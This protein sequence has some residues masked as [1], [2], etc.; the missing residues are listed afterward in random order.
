MTYRALRNLVVLHD[1][2]PPMLTAEDWQTARDALDS[3]DIKMRI[4][5]WVGGIV[6]AVIAWAFVCYLMWWAV[7]KMMINY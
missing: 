3:H 1:E 4:L 7:M 5:S 2:I 6:F